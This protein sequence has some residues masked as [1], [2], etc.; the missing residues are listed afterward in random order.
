MAVEGEVKNLMEKIRL[1][2]PGPSGTMYSIYSL[3]TRI[4]SSL[5]SA[6]GAIPAWKAEVLPLDHR[7]IAAVVC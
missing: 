6:R 4:V 2:R 3:R 7:C 1:H 5:D